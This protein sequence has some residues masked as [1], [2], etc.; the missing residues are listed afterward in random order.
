MAST[1]DSFGNVQETAPPGGATAKIILGLIILYFVSYPIYA[2]YLHPLSGYPGGILTRISRIPYWIACIQG[3]QVKFMTEQ[4]RKYGP[5]VRFAP[6]DLSYTESQAWRDICL[7]PKGKKENGKELKFHPLSANGVPNL[8]T[9]PSPVRHATVRR[10]FSSAFSEK[11][12]K[13]Q[14]PLF[15]KYA[16][17][18]VARGRRKGTVNMAELLNFT[19]FDIMAEFAFGESLGLLEKDAYSDWV[20]TVFNTL[21]VL[22]V[23]QFIQFYWLPR[24]L[25]SLLEPKPVQKMRLDHFNHTVTRVD[26][27][28]RDGSTKPDLWNL[29]EESGILTSEEI[30]NNAELFMTAGTETTASLL[31]GTTYYLMKNPD[32]MKILTDEIR[33]RFKSNE[34]MTFEALGQLE[35]LN[36]CLREGLR[37]YPSIP[38]AIPREIAEGGNVVMGKWLPGGI[39]VSV[40]QTAT[41]RSPANFRNPDEFVPERWLGDLSYKEDIREAHQPFGVG[42]RNCIGMNMAWHEM[43]LLLAKLIFNFDLQTEVDARWRDQN[44]FVIWDRKPLPVTLVDVGA[45]A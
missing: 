38:T 28:L 27:R 10:V 37:V 8:I 5:I 23:V 2:L 7:I 20:A 6:N 39:R 21:T 11:A 34:E 40:H 1:R 3:R 31:T 41:Y 29:V 25:F 43:R 16:N 30:Y 24:T 13:Q 19:T 44:V 33:R 32:K 45:P 14:E 9:E 22:P 4:H 15:Q 18:M 36:A 42:T 35:Y 12:L 26:K 17:L